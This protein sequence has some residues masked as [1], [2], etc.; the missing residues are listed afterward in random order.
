MF[1]VAEIRLRTTVSAASELVRPLSGM[2]GRESGSDL[3]CV[4][5]YR[6][7]IQLVAGF[8]EHLV[9]GLWR[10]VQYITRMKRFCL[11]AFDL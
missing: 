2:K 4:D 1:N 9:R 10:D 8:D 3:S 7:V 11:T 6:V 5:F